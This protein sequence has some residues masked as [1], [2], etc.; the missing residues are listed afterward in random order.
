MTPKN[1]RRFSILVILIGAIQATLAAGLFGLTTAIRDSGRDV[2]G[3]LGVIASILQ[4]PGKL[5]SDAQTPSLGNPKSIY[6]GFG[7]GGVLWGCA[8]ALLA[9]YIRRRLA[10][11]TGR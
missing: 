2:S 10:A 9:F 11:R 6:V 7:I 1:V 8:I 5:V 4:T 3:W